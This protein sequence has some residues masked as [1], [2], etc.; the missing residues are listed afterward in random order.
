MCVC[1]CESVC[2]YVYDSGLVSSFF[3]IV[4]TRTIDLVD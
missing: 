2:L 4:F 1:V 3:S